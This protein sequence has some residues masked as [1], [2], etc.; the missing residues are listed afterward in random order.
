MRKLKLIS[1]ETMAC[2][3]NLSKHL[4]FFY[5]TKTNKEMF[6]HDFQFF[7]NLITFFLKYKK[8]IKY[9]I[10]IFIFHICAKLQ[11]IK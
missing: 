9:S 11:T 7:A 2:S 1:H 10:F 4:I 6:Q 8:V 5:Q 3:I